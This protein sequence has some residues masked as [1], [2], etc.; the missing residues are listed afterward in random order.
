MKKAISE[1][2]IKLFSYY[3]L[4]V[5]MNI[6]LTKVFQCVKQGQQY[7]LLS[8]SCGRFE[9]EITTIRSTSIASKEIIT[10]TQNN[11]ITR[12]V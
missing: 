1:P 12:L 3:G 6:N 5:H 10:Q 7:L 2:I 9:N 11:V 4:R 8:I